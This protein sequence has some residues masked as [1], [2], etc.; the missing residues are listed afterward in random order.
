MART[1]SYILDA[2][3]L[4]FAKDFVLKQIRKGSGFGD[5]HALAMAF[6]GM[7]SAL[8]QLQSGRGSAPLAVAAFAEHLRTFNEHPHYRGIVAKLRNGLRVR[9]YRLSHGSRKASDKTI[10]ISHESWAFLKTVIR[11]GGARTLSEAILK[12]DLPVDVMAKMRDGQA[13]K[14]R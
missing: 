14:G 3:E 11:H 1:T 5:D 4:A 13:K 10:T 6:D 2:S 7:G 9:K 12:L 8:Q